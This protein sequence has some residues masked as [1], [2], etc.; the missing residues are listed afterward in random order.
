MLYKLKWFLSAIILSIFLKKIGFPTYIAWPIF[1]CGLKRV[2]IGKRVRIFPGSRIETHGDGIIDIKD[3]VAIGQ[4]FHITSGC[5]LI[6]GE[7]TLITA[8]VVI[9]NIDHDYSDIIIPIHCQQFILS[10]TIIGR[11]CFIGS[12]A[13]IQAGTVL[14]E[15][16]IVGANA[17]VKGIFPPYSVIVG[18]PAKIVKCYNF[19]SGSWINSHHT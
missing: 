19:E 5:N 7:G 15:H 18:V 10:D 8:N 13:I 14:G 2:T 12:G 16:C 1:S 4:N 11:N 9:T 6:I 17:V 3:N